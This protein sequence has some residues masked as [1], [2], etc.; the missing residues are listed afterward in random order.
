MTLPIR[1]VAAT[2]PVHPT[3]T[4]AGTIHAAGPPASSPIPTTTAVSAITQTGRIVSSPA[5]AVRSPASGASSYRL[6][7]GIVDANMSTAAWLRARQRGQCRRAGQLAFGLIVS[8][9][10]GQIRNGAEPS[11][12]A[13]ATVS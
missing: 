7:A 4:S 11:P 2:Q 6:A 13:R 1:C 10:R 12:D 3:A 9:Q 8:P 5:A